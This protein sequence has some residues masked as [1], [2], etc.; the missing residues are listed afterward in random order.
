MNHSP[1][2]LLEAKLDVIQRIA[3]IV[4]ERNTYMSKHILRMSHYSACL[5]EEAGL[6]QEEC[7]VIL[8]AS[9]LHD[10][11]KIAIPD[12]IL[13]KP[14]KLN[15]SEWVIMRSHT[16]IGAELLANNKSKFFKMARIIALTHHERWDG[17]GYPNNLKDKKIP[18]V[19]RIC[20]LC[21]VFDAL[22]TRR[23]YKTAWTLD[24][25]IE[26]IKRGRETHFD[27]ELVECFIKILPRLKN[28][29]KRYADLDSD[30]ISPE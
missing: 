14:G 24:Q 1:Y 26:E 4:E 12:K 25:T 3:R 21:D 7:R 5:A 28:I 29:R 27:P 6:S 2:K 22:M 11:G 10:I 23:P 8:E 19:G 9:G 18:L 30:R 17:S 13:R 15:S 20:G 16:V